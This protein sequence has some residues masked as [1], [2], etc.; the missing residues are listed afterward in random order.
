MTNLGYLP[1]LRIIGGHGQLDFEA[2]RERRGKKAKP[3]IVWQATQVTARKHVRLK[4]AGRV[5]AVQ[6]Q[7]L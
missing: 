4:E 7:G 5:L 1:K 6:K 2:V 3:K